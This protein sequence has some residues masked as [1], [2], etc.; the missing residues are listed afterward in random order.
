MGDGTIRLKSRENTDSETKSKTS[1]TGLGK[2]YHY[3]NDFIVCI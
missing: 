2:T 1:K 3:S